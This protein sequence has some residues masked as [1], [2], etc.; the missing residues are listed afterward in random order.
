MKSWLEDSS[1]GFVCDL[2]DNIYKQSSLYRPGTGDL[3][4]LE[5]QG[6][7]I[8]PSSITTK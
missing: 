7:N 1:F 3:L 6:E 5:T 8:F 2:K 4:G